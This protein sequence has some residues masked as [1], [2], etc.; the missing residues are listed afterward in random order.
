MCLSETFCY[1]YTASCQVSKTSAG[2]QLRT[3]IV[4]TLLFVTSC[5]CCSSS[6]VVQVDL[7]N[8]GEDAFKPELYGDTITIE[9]RIAESTGS[10][11]LKDCQ[12]LDYTPVL[13]GYTYE[14]C[15]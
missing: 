9:R 3:L 8:R 12:G 11:A 13:F 5:C 4:L 10:M 2:T 15:T 1:H 7:K 6:A 14:I